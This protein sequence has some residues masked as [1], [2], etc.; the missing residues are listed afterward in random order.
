[1]KILLYKKLIAAT[2]MGCIFL[3]SCENNI[4]EVKQINAKGI[5]RDESRQVVIRYSVNGKK[6]SVL[7]GPLMYRVQ[8]TATYV[9]FPLK[10][11]V[12]FFGAND[13]IESKLDAKYAKYN[14]G[15]SKVF[16]KD[17]VRV[18]NVLGDTLYCDELYWDRNRTDAEFYTDKPVKIRTR[19]QTLNGTGMDA[20][21]DFST[22][23]IIHPVGYLKVSNTDFPN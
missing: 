21:Q 15:Q 6:R 2:L 20:R 7:S 17:S 12:D 10:V 4:E 16:L 3:C 19:T 11:H 5:G 13:S 9:E 14:E 8:D 23:H 1:M 22:Y 18:I